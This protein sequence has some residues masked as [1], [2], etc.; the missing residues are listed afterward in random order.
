MDNLAQGFAFK[1]TVVPDFDNGIEQP[2]RRVGEQ[3]WS[4]REQLRG[5]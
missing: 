4:G 5:Q 1:R 3:R 2:R